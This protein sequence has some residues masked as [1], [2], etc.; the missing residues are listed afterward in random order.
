MKNRVIT[1][2]MSRAV[3]SSEI[4]FAMDSHRKDDIERVQFG[5]ARNRAAPGQ[6]ECRINEHSS[7]KKRMRAARRGM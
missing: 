1:T 4:A 7:L 2:L 3:M 5:G 6:G